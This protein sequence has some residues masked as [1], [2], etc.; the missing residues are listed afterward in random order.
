MLFQFRQT[1]AFAGGGEE[2]L[3]GAAAARA[4]ARGAAGAGT[5]QGR[6]FTRQLTTRGERA[7]RARRR[8][9]TPAP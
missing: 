6:A 7:A 1:S 2:N 3:T 5:A 4:L 9:P 8:A